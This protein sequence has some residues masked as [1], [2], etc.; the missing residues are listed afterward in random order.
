MKSQI[1]LTFL[2]LVTFT[3]FS[4]ENEELTA[5]PIVSYWSKGDVYTFLV[6]KSKKTWKEED[7]SKA[8]SSEYT[9]TFTV[10]DSTETSYTIKWEFENE[11]SNLSM[12]PSKYQS[13]FKKYQK[14]EVIY[15]TDE[16]GVFQ[17]IKNWKEISQQ[18]KDFYSQLLEVLKTD[19]SENLKTLKNMLDPIM[20]I[21]SSKEGIEQLVFK[22]IYYFHFPYGVEYSIAEPLEYEEEFPNLFGG[23]PLKGL[24]KI[25]V[26]GVDQENEIVT[27]LNTKNINEAD[28]KRFLMEALKKMG[29]KDKEVEE[30]MKKAKYIFTDEN[31]FVFYYGP[32]VPAFVQGKRL[33]DMNLKGEIMKIEEIV[34]VELIL[35]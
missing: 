18:M 29:F 19:E 9:A 7:L 34:Q 27:L 2:F 33:V 12:I 28:T 21:Y 15:T 11:Y 10:I 20:K 25:E 22:E 5:I 13:N 4:Q 35:E 16:V 30:E 1:L 24:A 32:G 6:K 23:D 8:D 31:K 3:L 17:G 26:I 14:N